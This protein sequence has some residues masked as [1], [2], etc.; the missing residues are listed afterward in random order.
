MCQEFKVS[1]F[2]CE[3]NFELKRSI[4]LLDPKISTEEIISAPKSGNVYRLI[5]RAKIDEKKIKFYLQK[6]N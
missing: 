6:L 4:F 5:A 2:I 1:D 3:T